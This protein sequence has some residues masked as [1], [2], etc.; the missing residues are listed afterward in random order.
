MVRRAYDGLVADEPLNNIPVPPPPLHQDDEM[1]RVA[2]KFA[3]E[4]AK[5][6]ANE[7]AKDGV[8]AKKIGRRWEEGVP[9]VW[10]EFKGWIPQK[11]L[12]K[13]NPKK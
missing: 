1:R 3:E 13:D 9:I 8:E 2:K 5:R 6:M 11:G 12:P 4:L 7:R 10:G